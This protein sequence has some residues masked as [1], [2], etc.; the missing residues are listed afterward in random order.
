M[1]IFKIIRELMGC[2]EEA[3][4]DIINEY[5][6]HIKFSILEK[7]ELKE[8]KKELLEEIEK[9]NVKLKPSPFEAWLDSRFKKTQLLYK[10][11]WVMK[12]SN[13]V[14]SDVRDFIHKDRSLPKFD[15]LK[16]IWEYRIK[17]VWDNFPVNGVMD[18]WQTSE[19]TNLLKAGDCEDS[20]IFRINAA[21]NL[22]NKDIFLALGFWKKTIG[23]AFPVW[24]NRR[25][26]QI[27]VLE[28]T[29]NRYNISKLDDNLRNEF[30]EVYYIA[31]ENNAWVINDSIRFGAEV[32]KDFDLKSLKQVKDKW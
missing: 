3:L 26:N 12:E 13:V 8:D 16:D 23:H 28:A 5:K 14:T 32:K 2:K 6:T 10:K 25:L 7:D 29:D 19:E 20:S 24:F 4:K 11:R 1:D 15:S 27:F 9:L 22:G 31:N 18:F 17:Y 30:Y 21:I